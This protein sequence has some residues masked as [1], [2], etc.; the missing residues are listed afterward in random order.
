M[1]AI[2]WSVIVGVVVLMMGCCDDAAAQGAPPYQ[3]NGIVLASLETEL[4]KVYKAV[5][6]ESNCRPD[7]LGQKPVRHCSKDFSPHALPGLPSDVKGPVHFYVN[8][9]EGRLQQIGFILLREDYAPFVAALIKEH[10]DPRT[11]RP[12]LM[13]SVNETEYTWNRGRYSIATYA[14][15]RNTTKSAVFY[16]VRGPT[17]DQQ[18]Q[19]LRVKP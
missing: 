1:K 13:D 16:S 9:V 4:P 3:F 10:G 2:E 6:G 17:D 19:R 15:H 5:I 11:A 8:Y 12:V 18:L 7:R 14:F